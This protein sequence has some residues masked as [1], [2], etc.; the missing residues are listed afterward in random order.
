MGGWGGGGPGYCYILKHCAM[1]SPRSKL[2]S[3]Y[4]KMKK[5]MDCHSALYISVGT[6][7]NVNHGAVDQSLN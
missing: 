5:R 6:A 3:V 2:E 4:C 1:F 7:N